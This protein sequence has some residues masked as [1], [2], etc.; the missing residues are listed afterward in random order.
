MYH[1]KRPKKILLLTMDG[2]QSIRKLLCRDT[3]ILHKLDDVTGMFDHADACF[4]NLTRGNK[5]V[6]E[7]RLC[8]A[9]DPDAPT[10]MLLS[11]TKLRKALEIFRRSVG[12]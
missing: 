4:V 12:S 11:G 9:T 2:A 10:G 3:I 5:T 8:L 6:D 7:V 1:D